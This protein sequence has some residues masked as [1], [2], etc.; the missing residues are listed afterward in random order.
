MNRLEAI[1]LLINHTK[2]KNYLEIGVFN[3]SNFLE[4]HAPYKHAV[5][6]VLKITGRY[7][8]HAITHDPRN[9]FNKYFN[10][11]SDAYFETQRKKLEQNKIDVSFIDG[12][13]TY[14]Q[15]LIDVKNVLTYLNPNGGIVMHDCS[16]P[17]KA[18]GWPANSKEHA[19]TLNIPGFTGG[20]CGDSWKAIHHL[21]EWNNKFN[22]LDIFVLNC[23]YGLG[24]VFP[25]KN[26]NV[27]MLNDLK[28][29]SIYETLSYEFLDAN[30]KLVIHLEDENYIKKYLSTKN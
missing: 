26:F 3:G 28:P 29:E 30:R 14:A 2:A 24:V 17:T 23:D 25:K 6:P 20:W 22:A 8:F 10:I 5:D 7:K 13:H 19:E 9:L 1:Q 18:H 15:T 16:P 11:T 4:V 27:S 12:L 21:I